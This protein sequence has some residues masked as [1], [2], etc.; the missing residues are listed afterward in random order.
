MSRTDSRTLINRGRKAG[1]KTSELYSALTTRP[2]EVPGLVSGQADGN[3][4][5]SGVTANGRAV[6]QPL[7]GR[8]G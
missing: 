4:F 1:L 8:R 2:P 3:G 5:V 6:Y 7:T